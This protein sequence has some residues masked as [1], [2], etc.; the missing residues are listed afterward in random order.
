MVMDRIASQYGYD[1][2]ARVW[3][4]PMAFNP[5]LVIFVDYLGLTMMILSKI[6]SRIQRH[7]R[8]ERLKN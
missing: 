6:R 1:G 4:N 8:G 5:R 3:V 2:D 7:M